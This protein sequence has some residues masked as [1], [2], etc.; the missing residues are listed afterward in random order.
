MCETMKRILLVLLF[1]VM[2]GVC[3]VNTYA[4]D[5]MGQLQDIERDSEAATRE[6][7]DEGAKDGSSLGFDTNSATP[8]DLSGKEDGVVDPADVK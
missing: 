6:P 1:L 4:G 8:V 2:S 5:A 3:S 7:T